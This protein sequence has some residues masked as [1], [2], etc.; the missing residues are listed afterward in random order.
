MAEEMHGRTPFI[1]VLRGRGMG[2]LGVPERDGA[3]ALQA[4]VGRSMVAW[5]GHGYVIVRMRLPGNAG[6]DAAQGIHAVGRRVACAH[7]MARL[8]G[9]RGR[10]RWWPRRGMRAGA[11]DDRCTACRQAPRPRALWWCSG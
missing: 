11:R 2:R 3:R 5:L 10:A 9:G 1:A 8:C 6:P 7:N 4:E